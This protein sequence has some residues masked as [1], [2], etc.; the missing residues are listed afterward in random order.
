M[1]DTDSATIPATTTT[2][3]ATTVTM[4]AIVSTIRELE[5]ETVLSHGQQV[6]VISTQKR[7]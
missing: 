5:Q 4:S 1:I 2:H 7:C 6:Q 3:T